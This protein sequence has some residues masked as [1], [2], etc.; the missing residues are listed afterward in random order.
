MG[1]ARGILRRP[2]PL[3]SRYVQFAAD[4]ED[5]VAE[6]VGSSAFG[7]AWGI[8]DDVDMRLVGL[9]W[10]HPESGAFP[11]Y[12]HDGTRG[13]VDRLARLAADSLRLLE[14]PLGDVAVTFP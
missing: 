8:D 13:D 3:P 12:C 2:K 11:N 5:I 4:G 1:P 14:T 6:C 10:V 9:G 7:G